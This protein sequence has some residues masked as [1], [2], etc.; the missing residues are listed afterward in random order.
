MLGGKRGLFPNAWPHA[1]VSRYASAD[2]QTARRKILDRFRFLGRIMGAALCD[3]FVA[4]IPIATEFFQ[5]VLGEK[6]DLV[7]SASLVEGDGGFMAGLGSVSAAVRGIFFLICCMRNGW[8]PT[9]GTS[10]VH[11]PSPAT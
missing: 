4:P 1:D 2:D 9:N 10:A 5:L 6:L 11:S 3:G 8:V 7:T